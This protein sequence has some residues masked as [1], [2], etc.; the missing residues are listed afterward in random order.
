MSS[1]VFRVWYGEESTASRPVLL[2]AV[3][4]VE[5]EG[6]HPMLGESRS[7]VRI[8]VDHSRRRMAS[9]ASRKAGDHYLRSG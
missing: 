3:L 5:V 4:E 8:R 6:L 7:S 2:L 9:I 1:P